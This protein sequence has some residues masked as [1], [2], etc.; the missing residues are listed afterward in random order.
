MFFAGRAIELWVESRGGAPAVNPVMRALLDDLTASG[1]VVSIRVP[2]MELIDPVLLTTQR[3]AL[4]LLKTATTLALSVAVADE[5]CGV[6]FL[7]GAMATLRA[8]DKAATVARLA[9]VG[10]PVP[11]TFLC[12]WTAALS[13]PVGTAGAWISKPTRGIH[14]RGVAVHPAFPTAVKTPADAVAAGG[15][16]VDDG[17]CLVQRRVGGDEADVKVYVAGERAFAGVKRFS[18]TSYATDEIEPRALNR[19]ETEIV[20]GV[21]E[22]LGLRCFGV[23]LRYDGDRPVII[24]TNPFPG[25][26]GFPDA[27][28]VLRL[29][30]E[31]TLR[32]VAQ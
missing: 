11:A 24:D 1:A 3:P 14:G 30:I 17:T 4:V 15:Y 20:R 8:H 6:P 26:R 22:A 10:L 7:N 19:A 25:Y 16:V 23:D 27:V 31:R 2:E 18:A 13:P 28:P 21:G 9:A 32:A 5:R 29:E 12:E